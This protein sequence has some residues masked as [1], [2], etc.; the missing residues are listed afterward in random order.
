MKR[1]KK[2]K[3]TAILSADWHTRGD[4]PVCRTDDYMEAQQKKIEFV[5]SLAIFHDCPIL[6]AGDFGH[7][8][9]WGD[10]LLNWFI[11]KDSK[12]ERP[13]II[14]I[15]GQHDLPNHRLDKWEEAGMGV[16]S[17]SMENFEALCQDDVKRINNVDIYPFS[18]SSKIQKM[19]ETNDI[20]VALMHIMVIKSQKEKLWHDQVAHSAKWYLRK[21]PC[22]DLIISGDNH[23]SFAV[24]YE[25][26]WLVNAGSLMRMSA[27]QIDHKPSVYLW[28]AED[29]SIERVYLPIADDVISREHIDVANERNE[30]IESFVNRLKET[31][32][33]GLSFESNMKEFFKTNKTRRKVMEKVWEAME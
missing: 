26:R 2:S 27:N 13:Q 16:L 33:L 3:P 10:R 24:E 23:Q 20:N 11:D 25:G 18:Y 28:Y 15:C 21:F 17:K 32:E 31:E 5:F 12:A 1:K 30:R 22:Y 14:T 9:M 7:K 29:N 19:N 6:V 8:P 4:R